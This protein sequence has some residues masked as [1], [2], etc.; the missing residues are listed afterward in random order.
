MDDI[1]KLIESMHGDAVRRCGPTHYHPVARPE[2]EGMGTEGEYP[3]VM[4]WFVIFMVLAIAAIAVVVLFVGRSDAAIEQAELVHTNCQPVWMSNTK[5]IFNERQSTG[6]WDV[7]IGNRDCTGSTAMLPTWD[8]HRGASDVTPDGRY[9][10]LET[11]YGT[12]RGQQIAEPGVGT[13][14]DIELLDRSTNRLTR[15]TTGR[16]GT[17]WA[18]IRDDGQRVSWAEMTKTP[19]E[20][21]SFWSHA[22][23]D[24]N[25]HVADVT[26]DGHLTNERVWNPPE[27]AFVE[28]YGWVGDKLIFASDQTITNT[29]WGMDWFAS[30][31]WTLPENDLSATPTRVSP[32]FKVPT[33]C[34]GNSWCSNWYDTYDPY[35]EFVHVAPAGAFPEPGTWLVVGIVWEQ[36]LTGSTWN[37]DP[38]YNGLDLWRMHP[39][40]SDRQRVT[41]MNMDRYSNVGGLVFDPTDPTHILAGVGH[42]QSSSTLDAWSIHP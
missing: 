20:S 11:D 4:R 26:A 15:L 28:T 33:W 22:L 7:R 27:E 1:D 21:S 36:D 5:L 37:Q 29:V 3:W 24:W 40:G 14:D 38:P 6:R 34:S 42:D 18:Q 17:I 13:G 9:V 2:E 16:K 25:L 31:I 35:N 30:Q 39:D 32:P 10:L 19:L 41:K 23:G 8:G 12:P